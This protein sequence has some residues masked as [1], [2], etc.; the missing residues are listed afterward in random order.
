MDDK[1]RSLFGTLI[2]YYTIRPKQEQEQAQNYKLNAIYESIF[3]LIQNLVELT[4]EPF[5]NVELK[6][7][8]NSIYVN[9]LPNFKYLQQIM[10]FLLAYM[11]SLNDHEIN[12]T[13]YVF[14]TCIQLLRLDYTFELFIYELINK[15]KNSDI[16]LLNFVKSYLALLKDKVQAVNMIPLVNEI[17]NLIV[18]RPYTTSSKLMHFLLFPYAVLVIS[19]FLTVN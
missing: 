16:I 4:I 15:F 2:D 13:E 12:L 5:I 1:Y 17:F 8:K 6:R 10:G 18:Y 14:N 11:G 19:T 9:Y 3:Y 7:N